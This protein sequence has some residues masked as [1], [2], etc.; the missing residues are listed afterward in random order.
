[1]KGQCKAE[2]RGE[3]RTGSEGGG[4]DSA[5]VYTT[6]T[7]HT[8]H[9][10]TPKQHTTSVAQRTAYTAAFTQHSFNTKA[11]TQHTAHTMAHHKTHHTFNWHYCQNHNTPLL[12]CTAHRCHHAQQN[13]VIMHS[14]PL[15]PMN[16][17]PLSPCIAHRCHHEQHIA[18][19]VNSTPLS[20]C[21]AHRCH[22]E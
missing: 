2:S 10:T 13:G 14:K 19:T 21:T 18:V 9:T 6:D 7:Q 5:L 22:R 11:L 8:T 20:L 12:P 3:R 17:T 1:M 15:S 16:S 4:E